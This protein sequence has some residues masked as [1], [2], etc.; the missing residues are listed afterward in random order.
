[1]RLVVPAVYEADFLDAMLEMPIAHY[2]GAT[3]VDAG[4]RANGDLPSIGDDAL[5]GYVATASRQGHDFFYCLNVACLGNREFT[6][7]GQRWLVERLGCR[8]RTAST[9]ST[10]SSTSRPP[11][12]ISSI[13]PST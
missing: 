12:S 13:F 7:E 10:R 4:L 3:A 2:Y 9:A 6:A 1:M 11:A 8:A 5:A